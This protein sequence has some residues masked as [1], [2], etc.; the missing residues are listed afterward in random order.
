[1]IL[2]P[3][4]RRGVLLA[5][6]CAAFGGWCALEAKE[7]SSFPEAI[8]SIMNVAEDESEASAREERAKMIRRIIEAANAPIEFW[9]KVTDQDGVPLEGVKIAYT[10]LILWG[11]DV[12][13]SWEPKEHKGQ[14]VSDATGSFGITGFKSNSLGLDSFSKPGYVYRGRPN[15]SFDFGGNMPEHKFVPQR[16]KPVCFAMVNERILGPL[17]HMEGRLRLSGDG[18]IGRWNLWTGEPD[19]DG[20][21]DPSGELTII[22][23]SELA[24]PA[25]PTHVFD[26]SADLEIVGGGIMETAWVEEFHRAPEAGYSATVPYSKEPAKRGIIGCAFYLQTRNGNYG[27]IQVEISPSHDG[28]TAHCF[29]TSDMNPRPGSRNLEPVVEE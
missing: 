4:N 8:S 13:V 17:T 23:R 16:D 28:R 9:G 14:A 19:D 15:H 24:A 21:P 26:W 6:W 7:S 3:K 29:I 25:N 27:R 10:G 5:I 1:V 18:T 12:G 22:F 2:S 11:N 20:E